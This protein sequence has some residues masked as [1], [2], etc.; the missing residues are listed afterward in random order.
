MGTWSG[1]HRSGIQMEPGDFLQ[2]P[3]RTY[4]AAGFEQRAKMK[5]LERYSTAVHSDNL[6]VDPRSTWSDTDVLGAAGLAA[7][8]EGLG[9]ALT[10]LFAGGKPQDVIQ[11][12]AE[13]T[14]KRARTLRVKAS[15]VQALDLA[16]AVLSWYQHG[17]CQPCGGTGYQRIAG[18][19]KLGDQCNHCGGAGRIPFDAQFRGDSLPLARWLSVEID[20]AQAAA[21]QAAM[22][23]LAP[24]LEL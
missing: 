10:R 19:P 21:G 8:H 17:T 3:C 11:I 22:A 24:R 12:M 6:A 20:R 1:M 14:F 23:I 4:G 18:T 7:R 15:Q 2:S 9:I 5:L 16:T 13:M